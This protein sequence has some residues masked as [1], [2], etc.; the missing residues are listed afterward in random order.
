MD[1]QLKIQQEEEEDEW[2]FCLTEQDLETID[3]ICE[4]SIT[5]NSSSPSPPIQTEN[6][7]RLP[8]SLFV[9]QKQPSLKPCR[10]NRYNPY[11]SQGEIT[12]RYPEI[13]F[14]GHIMYSRTAREAEKAAEELLTFVQTTKQND[15]QV[16]L[17]FDIEWKPTFKRGVAPGKA[18]VMQI[19]GSNSRCNVI[20][21]FHSGITQKLQSL[22][23]D[24]AVV[25]VGVCIA[26]DAYKVLQDYNVSVKSVEDLS[27]LANQKLGG[28]PRKWSLARL[29]ET[30]ICKQLPKPYKIRLG[31]WE[32]KV[33]S[34]EQSQ[35]A[36]A[37]AFVSW[38]LY[39]VL[40]RLPEPVNG[41]TE[42]IVAG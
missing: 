38:Y 29:T 18:A 15:G 14:K 31:N 42:E 34:K 7:R 11:N 19:C 32:A 40:L 10:N 12:M 22:L 20:H 21:I 35:Y 30:L 39:Q 37:D 24:P 6:L 3:A 41:S 1:Q 23:E 4:A 28:P 27:D 25:K 9:F 16:A 13:S 2:G 36:A 17:G 5:S 8:A 26:N 33:L